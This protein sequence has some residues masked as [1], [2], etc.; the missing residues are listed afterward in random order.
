M[1]G[2]MDQLWEQPEQET[3]ISLQKHYVHSFNYKC[4][5]NPIISSDNMKARDT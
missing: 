5:R 2:E 4:R 1:D 3:I